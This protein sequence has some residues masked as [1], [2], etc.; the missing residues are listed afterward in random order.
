VLVRGVSLSLEAGQLAKVTGANGSGKTTLLRVLA[1]VA[2]PREGALACAG[3]CAYVAERVAL[4]PG[5]DG[6]SWRAALRRLRGL[7]V[8]AGAPAGP[9][10]KG[11]LQRVVLQE[12]LDSG[13]ALLVLDEPAAGLDGSARAW[14]AGALRECGAAVVWTEHPEA[15]L[16]LEADIVLAL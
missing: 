5:V 16:A 10:S 1:G 6:R 4:P 7:A 11:Q 3:P 2:A 14:L 15:P 12:A 8:D 9:L 13:A